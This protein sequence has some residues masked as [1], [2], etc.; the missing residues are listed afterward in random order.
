MII[1]GAGIGGIAASILLADKGYDVTVLEKNDIPGGKIG[2]IKRNGYT[3]DQGASLIMLSDV[4]K[5]FFLSIGKNMADYITMT[6]LEKTTSFFFADGVTFSLHSGIEKN[7]EEI[8][9]MYPADADGFSKFMQIGRNIYS[10]LYEGPKLAMRNFHKLG[11]LDYLFD[12]RVI[13]GFMKLNLHRSWYKTVESCFKDDHLRFIFSYQATFMGMH[14]KDALGTYA[15]LPYAELT[16]GMYSIKGGTYAIVEGFVKLAREKGVKIITNS[17]VKSLVYNGSRITAAITSGS[18]YAADIFVNNTDGSYFYTRLM[19]PEKNKTY[20]EDRLKQMKHSNSY[21]TVN[22][23]LKKPITTLGHH[24]F[25][26]GKDWKKAFDLA[27]TPQSIDKFDKN[28]ICYYFLQPTVSDPALAPPGK[29]TAF[30]LMPV[31]GYDP[32]YDWLAHEE[33]FKNKLYDVIEKRDG[34]PLRDLI[35]EEI[36]MSPPRWGDKL[37]LW[38]NI[39]LGFYLNFFQVNGFRMPNKSKEMDNLYFVG[40]STIPGPGVPTCIASAELVV[41]RILEAPE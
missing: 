39:I 12:P 37:N 19:P 17:E 34:I 28:N 9:K 29:A 14:P 38:N 21:F 1:I 5:N 41:E 2:Q 25:F 31:C 7:K 36:V 40:A 33:E 30:I 13:T 20:T 6:N 11:G 24:S 4:Y 18:T 22:L 15:F 23:G 27:F 3:F 26:V 16:D 32:D 8:T 35:E 10:L